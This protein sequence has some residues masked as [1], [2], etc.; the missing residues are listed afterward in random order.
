MQQRGRTRR[1][2]GSTRLGQPG[3]HTQGRRATTSVQ[4]ALPCRL[5]FAARPGDRWRGDAAPSGSAHERRTGFARRPAG[6]R[7]GWPAPQSSDNG[8]ARRSAGI[9]SGRPRRHRVAPG[10]PPASGGLALLTSRREP[11]VAAR[12]LGHLLRGAF[13]IRR[14]DAASMA[15]IA[16]QPRSEWRPTAPTPARRADGPAHHTPPADRA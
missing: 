6:A 14:G 5:R 16:P 12:P 13:A 9:R 11:L 4:Q 1:R 15:R 3:V 8:L 10:S 7:P 2:R